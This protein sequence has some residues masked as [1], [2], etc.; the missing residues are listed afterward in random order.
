ME[1][2]KLALVL[3]VV[4]GAN[5]QTCGVSLSRSYLSQLYPLN[6][7]SFSFSFGSIYDSIEADAFADFQQCLSIHSSATINGLQPFAFRDLSSLQEVFLLDG[8]I[9]VIES[10]TFVNLPSLTT[11]NLAGNPIKTIRAHAFVNISSPVTFGMFNCELETI[12]DDAFSNVNI[13]S[14]FLLMLY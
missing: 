4:F 10:D 3:L 6:T 8:L 5:Q 2:T 1:F 14:L 12:D 11:I 7:T 13:F 9:P